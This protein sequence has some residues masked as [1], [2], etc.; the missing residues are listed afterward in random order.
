MNSSWM[1][2]IHDFF[3]F[4][5][6]LIASML[7]SCFQYTKKISYTGGQLL[8]DSFKD[9]VGKTRTYHE[10]RNAERTYANHIPSR[11]RKKKSKNPIKYIAHH[12]T[13]S[14]IQATSP[15]AVINV[16]LQII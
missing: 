15:P 6:N 2:E 9:S 3:P 12:Q 8:A 14:D 10:H 7:W 11:K 1:F 16:T 4:T 13:A 5:R